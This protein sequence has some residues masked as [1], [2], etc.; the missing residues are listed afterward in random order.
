MIEPVASEFPRYMSEFFTTLIPWDSKEKALPKRI[1]VIYEE[2][3]WLIK[4]YNKRCRL[5]GHVIT[6]REPEC[7]PR[8]EGLI[9]E[10]DCND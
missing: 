3:I 9:A 5:D 1:S 2:D 4:V 6:P 7:D 8:Y 10:E